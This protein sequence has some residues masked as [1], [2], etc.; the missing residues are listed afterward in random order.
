MNE[1]KRV[2]GDYWLNNAKKKVIKFSHKLKMVYWRISK[3]A[4]LSTQR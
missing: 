1:E 2:P 4:A 3:L